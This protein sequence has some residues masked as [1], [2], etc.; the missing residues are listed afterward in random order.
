MDER[1]AK[2]W[3]LRH[4]VGILAILHNN[5]TLCWRL[6][7]DIFTRVIR[8]VGFLLLGYGVRDGG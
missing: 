2:M 3:M 4:A 7:N 8:G 1:V 5:E 6:V